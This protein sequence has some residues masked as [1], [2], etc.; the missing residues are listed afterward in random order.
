MLQFNKM[1]E[2]VRSEDE[3]NLKN[4]TIGDH[5]RNIFNRWSLFRPGALKT[6][7]LNLR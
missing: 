3:V 1:A 2:S 4:T 5:N 7:L 6:D